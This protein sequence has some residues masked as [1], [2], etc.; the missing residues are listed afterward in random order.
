PQRARASERRKRD[1]VGFLDYYREHRKGGRSWRLVIA[2]D[3][4]DFV[5]MSVLP[6]ADYETEPSEEE[7]AH[8]LGGAWDHALAKLRLLMR[9][10]VEVMTSLARFI[11]DGNSLVIVRGNHDVEW[12]WEAVQKA[13]RDELSALANF[14][15]E[16]L[17]FRAWFYYEEGRVFIE[18]G[19]QYDAYCS[20]E[21]ILNPVSPAD[22]RRTVRSLSDVLVRYV[23]R[24]TRGMTE[25]GHA[26]AGIWDYLRFAA[27]LGFRGM[28]QLTRRFAASTLA[29]FSL[30]REH[31][32][33][34]AAHIQHEQELRLSA[35]GRAHKI[36]VERL[37]ALLRLHRPP[38]TKSL[39]AIFASVM[40]D[41]V[42]L[43]FVGLAML[44][45]IAMW[46]PSWRHGLLEAGAAT[47]A[48]LGI[49]YAWRRMRDTLEPSAELRERSPLIA[50][51]FPAALV[52][53]GHTHLPEK[54]V[55]ND[56]T[57]YVNLG[58]W[59]EDDVEDGHTPNLPATRT[60]L[61]VADAGD[62]SV[63]ELFT[64]HDEGPAVFRPEP[65][66]P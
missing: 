42:L 37:K 34:A 64:W 17:E 40:L 32:S 7:L 3:F 15:P 36:Q 22:P 48:L 60:H 44:F 45:A 18:H 13:F 43:A 30:W 14:A 16:Q 1:L 41:R 50:R 63:T 25:A 52:V 57:T 33:E 24:P 23:V 46:A 59:A 8:G 54:H 4:V 9:H 39:P 56:S 27:S 6:T 47:V 35:L 58:A 28:L 62:E 51:L 53:M 55:A 29:L 19:H 61:V 66:S 5:G 2:G 49:G 65:R 38:I 20:F 21:H 31:V 10:E 11:A 26:A 12:H